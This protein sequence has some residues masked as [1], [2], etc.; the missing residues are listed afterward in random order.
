MVFVIEGIRSSQYLWRRPDRN[1]FERCQLT[2]QLR[3]RLLQ[4]LA[5]PRVA[6]RL[7]LLRE[8]LP[9]KKQAIVFPVAL[10]LLGRNRRADGLAL[11]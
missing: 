8:P 10:L 3:E 7:Q 1:L 6:G 2:I 4:H 11:L 9:G 5:V